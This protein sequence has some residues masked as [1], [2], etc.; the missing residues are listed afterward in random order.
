MGKVTTYFK[1]HYIIQDKTK[2]PLD[3]LKGLVDYVFLV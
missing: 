1:Q 3:L 2:K